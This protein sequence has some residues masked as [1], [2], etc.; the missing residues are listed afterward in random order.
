[1]RPTRVHVYLLVL[2]LSL[3]SCSPDESLW[4]PAGSPEASIG[5]PPPG[6]R[7]LPT[8]ADRLAFGADKPAEIYTIK[9][10]GTGLTNLTNAPLEPAWTPVWAPNGS[11][12]AFLRDVV[13]GQNADGDDIWRVHL[14]VM[15]PDGSALA[16]LSGNG[17]SIP[18]YG[19][20]WSPDGSKLAY[21]RFAA[22]VPNQED[23][24]AVNV[25]GTG[26]TQLTFDGLLNYKPDWA[27]DG[28]KLVFARHRDAR[29]IPGTH[30]IYVM[31]ADGTG[32]IQLTGG[33]DDDPHWSPDAS[34]V[35]FTRVGANGN[36][37][38]F[39]MNS[40][41]SAQSDISNNPAIDYRPRWSPAGGKL[42]FQS[43]RAGGDEIFTMSPAGGTV[44]QLTS[45]GLDWQPVWSPDGKQIAFA[46]DGNIWLMN[47]N[48]SGQQQVT[49]LAG[50]DPTWKP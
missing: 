6:P 48:G 23:I 15:N 21:S 5:P 37:E 14:F 4:G 30:G 10:D 45:Q 31:N 36:T 12:I 22:G 46:R 7:P 49:A 20:C 50:Y 11:R 25:D 43:T 38:V 41:G 13:E 44:T 3:V 24:F 19:F 26:L 1:M 8:S 35:A 34:Q 28:S 2:S 18:N 29:G 33:E 16:D 17:G 27:P 9:V 47:A 42:L 39:V 40:N 32:K